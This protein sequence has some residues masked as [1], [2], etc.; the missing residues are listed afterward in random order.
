MNS[1]LHESVAFKLC[2]KIH[3]CYK[4]SILNKIFTAIGSCFKS[5][6]TN[7]ILVRFFSKS[8]TFGY[9][10]T[11]KIIRFLA[12]KVDVLMSKFHKAVLSKFVSSLTYSI[13]STFKKEAKTDFTLLI[14]AF[15]V[16]FIIGYALFVS[17]ENTWGIPSLLITFVLILI[18]GISALTGKNWSSW[19]V[20]S[21]LYKFFK[22]IWE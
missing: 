11:Y 8:P 20:N 19:F 22:F 10:R 2:N 13:A 16:P 18:A 15:L 17:I 14:S 9:S 7:S 6:R 1:F 4:N 3:A 5:S 21:H 12:G